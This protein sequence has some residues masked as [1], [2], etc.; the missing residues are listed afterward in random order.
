MCKH[1]NCQG[2]EAALEMLNKEEDR[3]VLCDAMDEHDH[4]FILK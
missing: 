2:G 1:D 3:I 4:S